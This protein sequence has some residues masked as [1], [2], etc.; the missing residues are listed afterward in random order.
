MET[1]IIF[2]TTESLKDVFTATGWP[3][4][5]AVPPCALQVGDIISSPRV[6]GLHF[7]VATRWLVLSERPEESEWRL[8]VEQAESPLLA[9]APQPEA[10]G[11]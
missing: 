11:P 6:R 4:S 10:P 3:A 8:T 2:L 7:R 5:L 1:R 9:I